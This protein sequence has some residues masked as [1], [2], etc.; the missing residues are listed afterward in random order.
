MATRRL[1]IGPSERVEDIVEAVGGATATKSIEL[2]FDTATT[3]VNVTAGTRAMT[4]E[5][6]LRALEQFVDYIQKSPLWPM[7]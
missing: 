3:I 6:V 2:T 4:R 5:E 7:S 1:S